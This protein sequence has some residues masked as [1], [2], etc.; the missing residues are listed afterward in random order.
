[1]VSE[2]PGNIHNYAFKQVNGTPPFGVV[3]E[4]FGFLSTC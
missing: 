2:A 3:C 4:Y 1:M